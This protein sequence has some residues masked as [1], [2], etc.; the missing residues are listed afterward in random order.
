MEGTD[1][2]EM[3]VTTYQTIRRHVPEG[4][5]PHSYRRENLR[6]CRFQCLS[7]VPCRHPRRRVAVSRYL[8]LTNFT[9]DN[10]G[11]FCKELVL[12]TGNNKFERIL[13]ISI[14]VTFQMATSLWWALSACRSQ[15]RRLLTLHFPSSQADFRTYLSG[16]FLLQYKYFV[17]CEDGNSSC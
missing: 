17:S 10:R 7:V 3:L 9:T 6:S 4:S 8:Q 11:R 12:N 13:H 15:P 2:S 1:S 16:Y 5:Y 14:L